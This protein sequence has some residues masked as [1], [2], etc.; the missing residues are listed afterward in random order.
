MTAAESALRDR[1]KKLLDDALAFG[2]MLVLAARMRAM[3]PAKREQILDVLRKWVEMPT[4]D[5][6]QR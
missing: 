2:G 1:M 5:G 3:A 4:E 6:G